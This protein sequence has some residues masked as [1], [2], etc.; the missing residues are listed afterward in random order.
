[1]QKT[2]HKASSRGTAEHKWLHSRFSFSFAD[3]YEPT[4]MGFGALRVL[5]DDVI[6]P[7]TGFDMHPHKDMEIVTIVTQGAVTHTDSLGNKAAVVAAGDVQ[8]MSAGTGVVHAEHNASADTKLKLFQLWITPKSMGIEP[9]YGQVSFA[10]GK[11]NCVQELVSPIG[12]G[13]KLTINQDA[14]ISRLVLEKGHSVDYR[15]K[16]DGN[17]V[18]VFVIDGTVTVAKEDLG[19]R[20]AL[21]VSKITDLTIATS[22]D[23]SLLIIEVP[24]H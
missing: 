7:Q 12:S 13:K 20:D 23:A 8:I 11:I 19:P 24:M 6:D 3:W 10:D 18:Y 16:V 22:T 15:I 9:R 5:N 17:G 14:C 4:R 2:L 1:M 21:G